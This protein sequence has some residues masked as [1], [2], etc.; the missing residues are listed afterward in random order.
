V[1]W[2]WDQPDNAERAAR[3]GPARVLPP[4]RYTPRRAA[5][6]LQRLLDEPDYARRAKEVGEEVCQEDGVRT[7]CDALERLLLGRVS[8]AQD[9]ADAGVRTG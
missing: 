6:E 5:A 2:A 1:P 9:G 8:H 7:A 4:R 3:L